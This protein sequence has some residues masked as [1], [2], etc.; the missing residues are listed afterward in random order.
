MVLSVLETVLFMV[1][2]ILFLHETQMDSIVVLEV[3]HKQNLIPIFD[4]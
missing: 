4:F 3:T 1:G 2:L